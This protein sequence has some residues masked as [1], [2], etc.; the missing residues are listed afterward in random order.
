MKKILLL[1]FLTLIIF[2]LLICSGLNV[3]NFDLMSLKLKMNTAFA[4]EGVSD[5]PCITIGNYN[6][7]GYY[8]TN[9]GTC[10]DSEGNYCGESVNCNQHNNSTQSCQS[11]WC[12]QSY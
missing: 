2:N 7:T 12:K 6:A 4:Q 9:G 10:T 11:Y 8:G 5:T 3:E 1:T